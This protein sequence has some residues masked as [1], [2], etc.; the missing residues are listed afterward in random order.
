MSP[1]PSE[2]VSTVLDVSVKVDFGGVVDFSEV[3]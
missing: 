1:G 2:L 3:P